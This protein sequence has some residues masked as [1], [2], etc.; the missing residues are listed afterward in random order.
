MAGRNSLRPI[1]LKPY[2]RRSD[3]VRS[4]TAVVLHVFQ[5]RAEGIKL[6]TSSYV[7]Q[8]LP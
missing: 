5:R 7:I 8:C 4:T 3:Q 1:G 6:A 2:I